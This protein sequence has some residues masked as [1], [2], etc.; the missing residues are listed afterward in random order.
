MQTVKDQR[1]ISPFN[2]DREVLK[3]KIFTLLCED[4]QFAKNVRELVNYDKNHKKP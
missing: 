4:K 2:L 3:D 1:K